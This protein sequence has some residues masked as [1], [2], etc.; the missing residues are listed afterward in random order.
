MKKSLVIVTVRIK[1]MPN[2]I[3][4]FFLCLCIVYIEEAKADPRV[5]NGIS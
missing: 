1:M 5:D 2:S 4:G 3:G